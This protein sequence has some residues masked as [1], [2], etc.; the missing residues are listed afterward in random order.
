MSDVLEVEIN[1]KLCVLGPVPS[2]KLFIFDFLLRRLFVDWENIYKRNSMA[3][4]SE[5]RERFQQIVNLLPRLDVD[6]FGFSINNVSIVELENIFFY[7]VD[8]NSKIL[9]SKLVQL[10]SMEIEPDPDEEEVKPVPEPG[11]DISEWNPPLKSS[12]SADVDL[13]A[14]LCTAFGAEG[15]FLLSNKLDR[16]RLQLLLRQHNRHH[17]DPEKRRDKYLKKYYQQFKT[18]NR[19][20]VDNALGLDFDPSILIPKK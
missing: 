13:L 1:G 16:C 9:P 12:G 11:Q 10:H 17:E 4:I 3:M 7:Q 2:A 14:G 18:E 20:V 8:S 15:A 19:A 5:K 6:E